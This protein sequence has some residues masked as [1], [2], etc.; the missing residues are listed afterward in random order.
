MTEVPPDMTPCPHG[1]GRSTDV[2]LSQHLPCTHCPPRQH[3][4][5]CGEPY[6]HS[7]ND[8]DDA[9]VARAFHET[10]ERL[11][12]QHGYETRTASAVPWQQVPANNRALMRHTVRDLTDRGVIRT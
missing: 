12:P 10:Y 6:P 7:A 5:K 8:C 9:L 11:A 2:C 3:C 4:E 1:C